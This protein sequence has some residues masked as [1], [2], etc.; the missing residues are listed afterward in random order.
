MSSLDDPQRGQ[1]LS[2]IILN[3]PS[4]KKLYLEVYA[5]YAE[6]LSRCPAEGLAIE[7]GAGAG[8]AKQILPQLTTADILPYK[9]V[10]MVFDACH[11]PFADES[12]RFFCMLNVFHHI[13]DVAACLSECQR[14]LKPGGRILIVDQYP[15]WLSRWIFQYAH[16]EPFNMQASQWSFPSTGPLSGA[17]GALAWMVFF[18]DRTMFEKDFPSLQL[19]RLRPH[20][21]LRYW[22]CGGLKSWSLIPSWLWKPACL[23]DSALLG[24]SPQWAS[25]VDVELVRTANPDLRVPGGHQKPET[26][27]MFPRTFP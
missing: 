15:G 10:D 20:T 6:T 3:K 1:Q 11:M 5:R 16:H 2:E 8:F 19:D 14:C 18:R 26:T 7:L 23:M 4:L 24:C 25:F 13:P 17:N 9:T 21:P 12:V 27:S 22:L